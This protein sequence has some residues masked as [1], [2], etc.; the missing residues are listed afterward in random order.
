M[1]SILDKI[2]Q[3]NNLW[4]NKYKP[5]ILD[6]LLLHPVTKSKLNNL[7]KTPSNSIFI[8]SSGSGKTVTAHILAKNI[9]PSEYSSKIFLNLNA[10]DDRG[11][12]LINNV[13]IPFIKKKFD[14]YPYK[15]ILINEANTI[16]PKA[17][18]QLANLMDSHKN[19][20]FIFVSSELN[21]ISDTIQSRC[22]ILYFPLLT[23][24]EIKNKLEDINKKEKINLSDDCLD[25]LVTITQRDLRQAINFFQVVS[26]VKDKP[27]TSEII[28]QLFDKPNIVMIKNILI[29]LKYKNKKEVLKI[30]NRVKNK[31]YSPNDIL[32]AILNYIIGLKENEFD[33]ILTKDY[34]IHVFKITSDYYVRINQG[35]ETWIQVYGC[36]S[37]I[38]L[39]DYP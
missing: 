21:D 16:T 7:V 35:I 13:I 39:E 32:L 33:E 20:K 2:S 17:Q 22:S 37:K 11:L 38:L 23:Y 26:Y 28:Y 19:C 36:L 24:K 25:T 14:Y 6:D 15:L 3:A 8:G 18:N 4:V 1:S 34:L 29:Y 12:N 31:G 27:I 10:S 5:K 30:I 9:I